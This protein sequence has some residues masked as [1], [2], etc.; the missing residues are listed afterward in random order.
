MPKPP[1]VIQAAIAPERPLDPETFPGNL[2]FTRDL[3]IRFDSAVT[4]LV[5]EN[6]S[7]K[8][9]LL[10]AMAV[11]A[12]L[13]ITGGS[14][15]ETGVELGLAERSL[16]AESLRLSFIRQPKDRY[17]FRAETQAHFAELLARRRADG[18]FA[19]DPYASYGG[20]P[21]HE[22]SH[23]EAFLGVMQS[24]FRSGLFFLDEPESAL[25]PQRQLTL[26][27]LMHDRVQKGETQFFIATHS[28]ILLT[29]PGATVF[30][31]D[32]GPL[33]TIAAD[34]TNHFQITRDIL[35]HP[36][37][38]WQHL[39]APAKRTRGQKKSSAADSQD[40]EFD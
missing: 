26:L 6:G 36:D 29:Y 3:S 12:R 1:Y 34:Q 37:R 32:F 38:Y 18:D 25:S 10:E 19:G 7:G 13:P 31:F 2:E 35:N 16:L 40:R 22:V 23:G 27:A 11:V 5:G 15:N 20:K 33:E 8:S 4:F 30:T 17:F 21:L 14:L 9:T 39:A 24:R 28:P